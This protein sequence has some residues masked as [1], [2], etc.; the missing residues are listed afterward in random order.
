MKSKITKITSLL[1]IVIIMLNVALPAALASNDPIEQFV[2]RL[3]INVLERNPDSSGLSFWSSQLRSG[4]VTGISVAHDFFFS[5]EFRNRNVDN[6]TFVDILYRT[7]L[8]READSG[9]RNFWVGQLASGL[10]R[11][12]VFA[13]FAGSPEF[14]SL[15]RRFG[16]VR[17]SFTPPPGG[18]IRVFVTRLYRE[19]LGRGPDQGG[20]DYWTGRLLSGVTGSSVAHGFVFSN[21]MTN[22]N[23]S[24]TNFIEVL[25]RTLMGRN[26]DTSGRNFWVGQLNEGVPRVNVFAGFVNSPE[27]NEICRQYGITRGVFNP[28]PLP[29]VLIP[30][31]NPAPNPVPTPAPAP[32]QPPAPGQP[33][34]GAITLTQSNPSATINVGVGSSGRVPIT[35]TAPAS[36]SV[37]VRSSNRAGMDPALYDVNGRLIADDQAGDFNWLYT[38]PA[39]QTMTIYA[40]EYFGRAARYTVAATFP[41]SSTPA[42]P[43][44]SVERVTLSHS[45]VDLLR[46]NMFTLTATVSPAGASTQGMRFSSSNT[47]VATV[48]N[49]GV[50]VAVGSGTAVITCTVGNVSATCTVVVTIPVTSVSMS[51]NRS[52]ATYSIGESGSVNVTVSPND[53]NDKSYRLTV[54]NSNV[55]SISQD[56][57]FTCRAPGTAIITATASNGV[58][59]DITITVVDLNALAA[60]VFRLVNLERS[61]NGL[62]RLSNNNSILNAAAMVRARE[63]TTSFSHTRPDGRGQSTAYTDLGGRFTGVFTGTGENIASSYTSPATVMTAW[64]NSS[65][66]RANILN[67]RFTHLGVGVALDSTG[68]L[69]WVQTFYG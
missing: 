51:A 49:N 55:L 37:S 65:G 8:N 1:L 25:Y 7:L 68:K 6:G 48:T 40:G 13:G 47:S 57:R 26:S 36:G 53:A 56:G 29:P 28:P 5:I 2:S 27:F 67:P 64:M 45:R 41:G 3:Y 16:I 66:H 23:L 24:N 30:A 60:E 52:R 54:N 14:D 61:G 43:V 34:T 39:G 10:P 18:M 38:I 21:E 44:S 31:P 20:L 15:C 11:V 59:R 32:V 22:R 42:P 19:T 9:G 50:V 12:D 35:I 4:S 17:G 33:P 63:I 58:R 46:N 69:L 62:S